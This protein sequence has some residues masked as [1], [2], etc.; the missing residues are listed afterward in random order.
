M[1]ALIKARAKLPLDP[2]A[3]QALK[4]KVTVPSTPPSKSTTFQLIFATRTSP[5]ALRESCSVEVL[6]TLSWDGDAALVIGA[7]MEEAQ[8]HVKHNTD[9]RCHTKRR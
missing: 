7:L 5:R 1:H 6:A 4:D 3:Q 8:T 2:L 9:D